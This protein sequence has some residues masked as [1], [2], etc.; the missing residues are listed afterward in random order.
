MDATR[1]SSRLL[2]ALAA[3]AL[4]ACQAAAPTEEGTLLDETTSPASGKSDSIGSRTLVR[5]VRAEIPFAGSELVDT[6][7][8]TTQG[9][10]VVTVLGT[11]YTF[12]RKPG[13]SLKMWIEEDSDGWFA[14]EWRFTL[15]SRTAAAEPWKQLTF[16]GT[17]TH[18]EVPSWGARPQTSEVEFPYFKSVAIDDGELTFENSRGSFTHSIEAGP[19]P[20]TYGVFAFPSDVWG[21]YADTY[22]YRLIADCS[23]GECPGN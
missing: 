4:G 6:A 14:P 21:R 8:V 3:L 15:Y 23:G 10:S 19:G 9:D 12:E 16:P 20:V 2:I 22:D 18:R 17:I 5:R 7:T 1:T 13:A 11:L